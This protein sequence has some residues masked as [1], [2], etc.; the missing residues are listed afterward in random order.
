MISNMGKT[1]TCQ[2]HPGAFIFIDALNKPL[3]EATNK[4]G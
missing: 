3:S 4:E 1:N 2:K